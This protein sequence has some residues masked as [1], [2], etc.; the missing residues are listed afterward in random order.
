MVVGA[1]WLSQHSCVWYSDDTDG[2]PW[3]GPCLHG[4]Q[5]L[6]EIQVPGVC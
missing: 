4:L 6:Q 3:H 5:P 1:S 2:D